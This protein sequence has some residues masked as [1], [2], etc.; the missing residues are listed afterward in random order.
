MSADAKN[1]AFL[2]DR[3]DEIDHVYYRLSE[4]LYDMN[5]DLMD[6][7]NLSVFEDLVLAT[8]SAAQGRATFRQRSVP[9]RNLM[10][11][12]KLPSKYIAHREPELDD[13][14]AA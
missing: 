7:I 13:Q 12:P 14:T 8:S 2:S 4:I 5:T 11:K 10:V 1:E 6:L 3:R 9:P